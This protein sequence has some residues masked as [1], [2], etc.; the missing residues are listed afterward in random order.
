[1]NKKIKPKIPCPYVRRCAAYLTK[2][3]AKCKNNSKAKG[4]WVKDK[5]SKE[6]Y[7]NIHFAG[8]TK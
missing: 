1:M 8:E 3:C 6:Y 5:A 4:E 7:Y 2:R